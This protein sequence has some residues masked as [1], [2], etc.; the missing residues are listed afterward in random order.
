MPTYVRF[1][2]LHMP[3]RFLANAGKHICFS[4]IAYALRFHCECR[5]TFF[6]FLIYCM[7]HISVFPF[8]AYAH[9]FRG[10]RRPT[11]VRL[12]SFIAYAHRFPGKCMPTYV[13]FLASA[14]RHMLFLCCL[15][16]WMNSPGFLPHFPS[17]QSRFWPL[18]ICERPSSRTGNTAWGCASPYCSSYHD[19]V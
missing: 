1:R 15:T 13:N 12:L 7:C 17:V 2:L 14:N 11:H 8:I 9:Q 4:C 18:W 16:K 6:V 19:L 10:K 5:P 3:T